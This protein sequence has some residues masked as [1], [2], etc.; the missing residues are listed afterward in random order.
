MRPKLRSFHGVKGFPVRT[1]ML[2]LNDLPTTASNLK[3]S[4]RSNAVD[5]RLLAVVAHSPF[6]V[7]D[8]QKVAC[9]AARYCRVHADL[10]A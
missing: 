1:A 5:G 8:R 9:R 7:E 4:G 3:T 6:A 10:R 2:K